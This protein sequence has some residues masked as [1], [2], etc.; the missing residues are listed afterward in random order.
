MKVETAEKSGHC[1]EDD[2]CS[3]CGALIASKKHGSKIAGRVSAAAELEQGTLEDLK[4]RFKAAINFCGIDAD[5]GIAD[6]VLADH[7]IESLDVLHSLL[8]LRDIETKEMA[9][10]VPFSHPTSPGCG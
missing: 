5:L 6:D 3:L 2:T 8:K 7:L 9:A 1:S 4:R 10:L